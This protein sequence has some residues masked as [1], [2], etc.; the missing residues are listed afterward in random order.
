[1]SS[2]CALGNIAPGADPAVTLR[3]LATA[4][5][6]TTAQLRVTA[7]NDALRSNDFASLLLVAAEGS[8]LV[9]TASAEPRTLATRR[10]H[11]GHP[12]LWQTRA[13]QTPWMRGL[14]LEIPAASRSRP[15]PWRTPAASP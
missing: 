5:G 15:W 8:D 7:A 12:S 11:H 14:T 10:Q 9:A 6:N 1:M 4:A 13:R 3:L 2:D